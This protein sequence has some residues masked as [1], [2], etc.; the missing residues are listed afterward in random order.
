MNFFHIYVFCFHSSSILAYLRTSTVLLLQSY[1]CCFISS[2]SSGVSSSICWVSLLI[3]VEGWGWRQLWKILPSGM[4]QYFSPELGIHHSPWVS[5]ALQGSFYLLTIRLHIHL[6]IQGTNDW[7]VT[8]RQKLVEEG[9]ISPTVFLML[10]STIHHNAY[11][12]LSP[13]R[14]VYY[15]WN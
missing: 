13:A 8:T 5:P 4:Y 7:V 12:G 1:F 6:T 9:I 3:F 2:F 15:V 11:L 10:S 14:C